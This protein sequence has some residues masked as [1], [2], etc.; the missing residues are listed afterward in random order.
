MQLSE[1]EQAAIEHWAYFNRHGG[2][3]VVTFD[4]PDEDIESVVFRNVA[5][6][7]ALIKAWDRYCGGDPEV[8]IIR[9]VLWCGG[10]Y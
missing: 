1:K 9:D 4:T 10:V 5:D 7:D 2:D 6:K 8:G 3:V